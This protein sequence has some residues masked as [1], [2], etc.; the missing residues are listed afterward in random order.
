MGKIEKLLD[1]ILDKR[2]DNNFSFNDLCK[3]ADYY[4]FKKRIK[5]GH[6]IYTFE[7]IPEIINLQPDSN[8]KAKIYQ[9]NQMRN[10]ILKY[11]VKK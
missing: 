11:F 1:K 3:I 8:G 6:F 10:L 5:G 7:E 2:F 4:C 9:V